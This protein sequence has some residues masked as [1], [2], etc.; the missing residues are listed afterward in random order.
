MISVR[1][2]WQFEL[3]LWEQVMETQQASWLL[4][5]HE[6]MVAS[7]DSEGQVSKHRHSFKIN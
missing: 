7:E 3:A 6:G 4:P 5:A 2:G 1:D